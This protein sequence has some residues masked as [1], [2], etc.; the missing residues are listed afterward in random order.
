MDQSNA[1][2]TQ[3]LNEESNLAVSKLLDKEH[4]RR[5]ANRKRLRGDSDDYHS[6]HTPSKKRKIDDTTSCPTKPVLELLHDADNDDEVDENVLGFSS[7]DEDDGDGDERKQQNQEDVMMNANIDQKDGGTDNEYD[8]D[9][10]EQNDSSNH[11]GHHVSDDRNYSNQQ[12]DG[13]NGEHSLQND[14]YWNLMQS[15]N[16]NETDPMELDVDARDQ[17]SSR[18]HNHNQ[19]DKTNGDVKVSIEIDVADESMFSVP[20]TEQKVIPYTSTSK[21]VV[22]KYQKWQ[23]DQGIVCTQ[24]Q[25]LLIAVQYII[26][27]SHHTDSGIRRIWHCW[28]IEHD[29]ERC[30]PLILS[31]NAE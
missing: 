30:Y 11:N 10:M 23:R 18:K 6:P 21:R 16:D 9:L 15:I 31:F 29:S 14:P 3:S 4:R 27:W 2:I 24:V 7:S 26:I 17:D 8:L 28:C 19:K 1:T 12:M 13:M 5:E 22:K 25:W 20:S